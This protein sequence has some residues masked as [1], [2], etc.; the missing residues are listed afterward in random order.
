MLGNWDT[1]KVTIVIAPTMTSKIEITIATIG[2]FMKNFD[3]NYLSLAVG[4]LNEPFSGL[5]EPLAEPS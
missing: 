1:G 5:P 2:R 4:F 3:M